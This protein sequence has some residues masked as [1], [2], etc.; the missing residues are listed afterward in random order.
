LKNSFLPLLLL[1]Q[2]AFARAQ[3][4]SPA[5]PLNLGFE[6]LDPATRLPDQWSLNKAPGYRTEV[7]SAQVRQ[8]RYALTLTR[9][10]DVP[11]GTFGVCTYF[12][13]ASFTGASIELKG[14]M[15]TENVDPA[16]HAGLWMRIDGPGGTLGFDNMQ[17]RKITGTHDWQ[18][19]VISLSLPED[20]ERIL[21]GGLVVG[22]G[23]IW[24]DGLEVT[25][26]GK[27]LEQATPKK[28]ELLPAQRDSQFF[29]GS[30]LDFIQVTPLQRQSLVVLG[31]V[32]GLIKYYHPRVAAGERQWDFELFR[33]LPAVLT[34]RDAKERDRHL[35]DWLEK[36]GPLDR[37]PDC[38]PRDE[39]SHLEPD[40]AWI[41]RSGLSNALEKKLLYLSQN[42]TH[43]K[44]YYVSM[45]P[46]IGNPSFQHEEAYEKMV[47]PDAGFRLLALYRYWNM[48]QYFFPYKYA[49]GEDWSKVLTEFVPRFAGAGNALEYRLALLELIGRVHDTHANLWVRDSFLTAYKGKL[50]APV[51]VKFVEEQPV[52]TAWYNDSLGRQSGLLPG[53]IIL[54]VDG[55][56]VR[57]VV[58]AKLPFYPAS[59]LPTKLRDIGRD[60]L[61][62]NA[63]TVELGI[64]RDGERRNLTVRRYEPSLLDMGANWAYA[65]PDSCYRLLS[66]DIGYINLGNIKTDLL[67]AIF[68]AFE[69]T[70]GI[71]IDIRNYPAEFVVF[72]LGKYLLPSQK[73]F[74]KFTAGN[75]RQPGRFE[76]R[77]ALEV[78][79]ENADYYKGKVVILVNEIT[80]SQAEYTTMALRQAPQATVIGSTTAGADGNVSPMILPGNLRTMISGIGVFYPDGRETQRVGIV[81]DVEV[82]PTIHGIRE[83]RDEALEKAI[84]L[85]RN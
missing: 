12:I 75:L 64:E 54:T 38:K 24:L 57:Q 83:G 66:P 81:P 23:K 1:L 76:W 78:G 49:I 15:K 84:E 63:P 85:I 22:T 37:C 3:T 8:G 60:F 44:H 29:A 48:I 32:W 41:E 7:D 9:D 30:G 45:V 17:S 51:Q 20:A 59:N 61:R 13:P 18:Q 26:D 25:V 73:Q 74:V 67:P 21:V 50:Y 69:K 80:Q 36:L 35:L 4:T 56:P 77:P 43:G 82:R 46:N 39:K 70:N 2:A 27:P 79:E 72:T 11:G 68:K 53:D 10:P 42:P 31:Q 28:I 52:V 47:Y 19:H 14:F 62:G 55:M 58:D 5:T 65:R 16:G 40:L 6:R 34:S 71:V 33:V